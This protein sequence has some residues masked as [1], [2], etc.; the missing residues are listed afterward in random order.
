MVFKHRVFCVI[1]K[2]C[3][4]GRNSFLRNRLRMSNYLLILFL[5]FFNKNVIANRSKINF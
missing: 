3:V 2:P 5:T 1:K 4:I